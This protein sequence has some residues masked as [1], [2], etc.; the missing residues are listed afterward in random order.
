MAANASITC[1][2]NESATVTNG[3]TIRQE[4]AKEEGKLQSSVLQKVICICSTKVHYRLLLL[5][6]RVTDKVSFLRAKYTAVY[7]S[8]TLNIF[9]AQ[10]FQ[11]GISTVSVLKL[12][13]ILP[14]DPFM[15]MTST[16]TM[17]NSTD[18]TS[19]IRSIAMLLN[20]E[21]YKTSNIESLSTLIISITNKITR[22]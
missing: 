21:I 5:R 4:S 1:V 20:V 11:V 9:G 22:K 2:R 18:I 17:L 14:S 3:K 19:H 10:Q 13:F 15:C 8:S 12:I 16:T 7:R 6:I